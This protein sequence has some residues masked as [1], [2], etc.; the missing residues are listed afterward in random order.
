MVGASNPKV[1][2]LFAA[3]MPQF[4][5]RSA[6][7]VPLQLLSLGLVSIVIALLSDGAWAFGAS[8]ARSPRR[9]EMLGRVGG[10]V[11][12]GLGARLAFTGRHD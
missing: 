11:M 4:I 9:L 7:H 6:G 3:I 5:D 1:V 2:I 12:I 10:C 8:T